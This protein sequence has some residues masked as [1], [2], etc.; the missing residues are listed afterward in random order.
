MEGI[1]QFF[2]LQT[3][4]KSPFLGDLQIVALQHGGKKRPVNFPR[5]LRKGRQGED[6]PGKGGGGQL[7]GGGEGGEGLLKEQGE[8]QLLAARRLNK[9]LFGVKLDHGDGAKQLPGDELRQRGVRQRRFLPQDHHHFRRRTASARAAET[10]EKAGNTVRRAVVQDPLQNAD[11]DAQLQR[12]GGAGDVL[13]PVAVFQLRLGLLPQGGGQVAVVDEEAIL[14]SLRVG[15]LPE[16]RGD[17]FGLLPGI[18][19]EQTRPVP[20]AF[21]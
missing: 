12:D 3:D 10:L 19:K 21:V 1:C 17:V 20:A 18:G 2:S 11:V 13:F 14:L 4:D 5:N 6:P 16:G 9:A 8:R 15:D 7:P